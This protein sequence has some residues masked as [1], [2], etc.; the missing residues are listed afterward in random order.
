MFF[1]SITG[2]HQLLRIQDLIGFLD[3]REEYIYAKSRRHDRDLNL[4]CERQLKLVSHLMQ[5][6]G[7]GVDKCNVNVGSDCNMVGKCE[8]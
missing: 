2:C 5:L 1:I 7:R 4:S 8:V 3:L 6:S